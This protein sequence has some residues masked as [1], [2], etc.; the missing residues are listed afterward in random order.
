MKSTRSIPGIFLFLCLMALFF[1]RDLAS[2]QVPLDTETLQTLRTK[3]AAEVE[4]F[5]DEW[6][7]AQGR[8]D[9]A[10][11]LSA[12]AAE[13]PAVSEHAA[14]IR[15]FGKRI[16][17]EFSQSVLGRI[18]STDRSVTRGGLLQ[19]LRDTKPENAPLIAKFLTDERPGEDLEE[20][21]KT[22][23]KVRES[24]ASG[25]VPF[26]V[27]DIAFNLLQEITA[28]DRTKVRLLSRSESIEARNERIDGLLGADAPAR[29]KIVD[30]Q[31]SQTAPAEQFHNKKAE[32]PAATTPESPDSPTTGMSWGMVAI[33]LVA[34]VSLLAWWLKR[35][36]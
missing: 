6:A 35:R 10:S 21:S 19:L 32:V 17:P 18:S 30:Q 14:L 34:I 7:A 1:G 9:G 13:D 15:V 28:T 29:P 25:A 2:G 16:E 23:P 33:A 24:I 31:S 12:L 26:R 20:R 11:F 22:T 3:P 27:C 4:K 36:K 5:A 8:E